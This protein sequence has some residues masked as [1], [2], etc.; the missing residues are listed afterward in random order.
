MSES[1]YSLGQIHLPENKILN[2]ILQRLS[3][4][5]GLLTLIFGI[6]TVLFFP[7]VGF[8]FILTS[9]PII[10]EGKLGN[11]LLLKK[12]IPKYLKIFFLSISIVCSLLALFAGIVFISGFALSYTRQIDLNIGL[13]F[14]L[15]GLGMLLPRLKFLGRF[16]LAQL[17]AFVVLILNS[18][19]ILESLYL[20]SLP[21]K[22]IIPYTPLGLAVMFVLLCSAILLRW[23]ARGLMS[24][25][26]TDSVSSA[27]AFG[28]LIAN[29]TVIFIIGYIISVLL[30]MGI[31]ASYEAI[32]VL[33]MILIFLTISFSWINVRLLYRLELERFVMKEELRIHNINLQL[34]NE[35]LVNKMT[36]LQEA[37]Q[38]YSDK[39]NNREKYKDVIASLE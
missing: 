29:I 27:Y 31:F 10:V 15:V 1:N 14:F 20:Q 7:L 39:L 24:M 33:A 17:L 36:K 35:D 12:D 32:A 4:L 11:P 25:F 22:V 19:V 3:L 6:G 9:F 30:R 26:T 37:N 28:L 13:S 21:V 34:G 8:V 5:F 2:I 16:H 38:E 23:P 18:M